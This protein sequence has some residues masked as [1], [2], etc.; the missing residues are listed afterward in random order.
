VREGNTC[1]SLD[2]LK[3]AATVVLLPEMIVASTALPYGRAS[4]TDSVGAITVD[5]FG[6]TQNI[7]SRFERCLILGTRLWRFGSVD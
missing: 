1:S 5:A 4:D 6:L 3:L 2:S 7:D